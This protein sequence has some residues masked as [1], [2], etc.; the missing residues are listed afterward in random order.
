MKLPISEDI[1]R[2]NLGQINETSNI[3]R[4]AVLRNS[5]LE[6]CSIPLVMECSKIVSN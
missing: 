4:R 6:Y 5:L 3:D 2:R 1:D